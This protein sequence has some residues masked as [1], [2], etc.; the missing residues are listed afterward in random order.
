MI[1]M[2]ILMNVHL[3][4]K[5]LHIKNKVQIEAHYHKDT[6]IIHKSD[7]YLHMAIC[8]EDLNDHPLVSI[9][10]FLLHLQK[11]SIMLPMI[12][13][14]LMIAIIDQYQLRM[15]APMVQGNNHLENHHLKV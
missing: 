15:V 1:I 7:L 5:D 12:Q 13:S 11:D 4:N 3:L 2:D 6:K 8:L 10:N 9:L 14:M